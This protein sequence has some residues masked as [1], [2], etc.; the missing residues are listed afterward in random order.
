MV[1]SNEILHPECVNVFAGSNT[2][3]FII[4]SL[5]I[6][7]VPLNVIRILKTVVTI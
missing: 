5:L 4:V 7:N 3:F 6:G 1:F 2:V